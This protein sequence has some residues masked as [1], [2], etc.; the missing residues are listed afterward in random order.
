VARVDAPGH[1]R[2]YIAH[3]T[4]RLAVPL[5]LPGRSLIAV[6][7][8]IGVAELVVTVRRAV[9]S[10]QHVAV[11]AAFRYSADVVFL[12]ELCDVRRSYLGVSIDGIR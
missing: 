8:G 12:S 1:A 5:T 3:I 11:A 6:S 9:K 7:F 2:L 4:K 10:G